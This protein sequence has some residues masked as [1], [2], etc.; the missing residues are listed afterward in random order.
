MDHM[1]LL[2][3]VHTSSVNIQ[4]STDNNNNNNTVA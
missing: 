4:G 1:D 2:A 3:L